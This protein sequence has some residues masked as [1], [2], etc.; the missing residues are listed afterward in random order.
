M[1]LAIIIV[2]SAVLAGLTGFLMDKFGRKHFF[3]PLV[4]AAVARHAG[5]IPHQI[6]RHGELRRSA[7]MLI[8]VGIV[9]MT[10]ELSVSGLFVSSFRDYIPKG[11]EGVFSGHKDVPVRAAP[12][13]HRSRDRQCD[14]RRYGWYTYSETM[15]KRSSTIRTRCPRRG[16]SGG[17]HP[18]TG[19]HSP[20]QRRRDACASACG[21]RRSAKPANRRYGR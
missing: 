2:C 21:T 3:I 13:D 9:T 18:D 6:P 10:A 11:K 8:P 15:E 16:D 14:N 4:L 20:Q 5:D 17:V 7:R 19:G 12:D 1:P